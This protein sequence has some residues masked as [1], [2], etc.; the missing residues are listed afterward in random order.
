[1]KEFDFLTRS[2]LQQLHDLKGKR[3]ANRFLKDIE[4]YLYTFHHGTEVVYYLSKAG[5]ERVDDNKIRKKTSSINHILIRNQLR[6]V[7]RNPPTW[8]NEVK[9]SYNKIS[10]IADAKYIS[11]N[12][13]PVL[14]EVDAS[15]TM[16]INRKKIEKYKRI[17]EMSGIAFNLVWVTEL[18]SRRTK[19]QELMEGLTGRVYTLGDIR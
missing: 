3:N 13:I 11:N 14:V 2:Q 5:R 4:E 8:E 10:I 17:K 16:A 19:L 1:M 6:I 12:N 18:E 15:Q 7:L 9:M